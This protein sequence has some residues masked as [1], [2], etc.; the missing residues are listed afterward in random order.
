MTEQITLGQWNRTLLH[1]QHLL[2][3]VA[4]D[5]IEVLDRCV[6]LQSQ[7]PKA[8]FFGLCSRIS[9]FDPGELDD[10]L[11]ER[12]VVR[13]SLLRGTVFTM[14]A[15]DARWVR[16]LLTDLHDS[17]VAA[18]RNRI[19][20]AD[21]ASVIA[22]AR[23]ILSGSTLPGS[24]LGKQLAQRYPDCVPGELTAI[25]RYGLPLVQVPPRGLWQGRG[26]PVYALFDDW[27]G[28]GEPAVEGDEARRDLIRL[29]LR[30]F[31]PSTVEGIQTWSGL[32]GLGG[33]VDAM[34]ADWELAELAGPDGKRLVDLEGLDI[35]DASVPAPVRLVAPFDNV[36]VAQADRRRITDDADFRRVATPNGR[37]PGFVLVDGRLAGSWRLDGGTPVVA[38]HR[39]LTERE[40]AELEAEAALLQDF[41][42]R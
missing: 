9:D 18:H 31:G 2:D 21:P 26:A 41:C 12:E 35:I 24:E 34:V 8:Q 40:N 1:R 6:G 3:R 23:E 10:L 22:D 28:P 16:P 30:G 11:T 20:G 27:A 25:A 17:G 4:E 42:R 32:T 33:I 14:D 5:A 36:L 37:F 7:D 29:Y 38:L 19:G 15:E 13:M 39:E